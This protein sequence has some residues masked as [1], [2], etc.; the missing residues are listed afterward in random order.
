MKL[1]QAQIEALRR[2]YA[3]LDTLPIDS[4][5]KL[6][7]LA[8]HLDDECIEDL[9]SLVLPIKFVTVAAKVE[10]LKRGIQVKRRK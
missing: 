1:N 5:V 6:C 7:K 2:E 8:R 9:A 3:S 4:A 10:C